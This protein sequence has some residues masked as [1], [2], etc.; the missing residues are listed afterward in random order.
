LFGPLRA[1]LDKASMHRSPWFRALF[2]NV[3]TGNMLKRLADDDEGT[4][5]L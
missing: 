1:Q 2:T 3:E 4:I 5:E